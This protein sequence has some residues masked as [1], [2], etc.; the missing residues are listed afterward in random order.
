MIK[1]ASDFL[2][3]QSYNDFLDDM[4]LIAEHVQKDLHK[5]AVSKGNLAFDYVYLNS[6][7]IPKEYRT[8]AYTKHTCFRL[9]YNIS[10]VFAE[11]K[12]LNKFEEHLNLIDS[13]IKD[14]FNVIHS[15]HNT[16]GISYVVKIN[17]R[18][19]NMIDSAKGIKKYS[20]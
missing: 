17:D 2:N 10:N 12:N 8:N 13:E 6:V 20:L 1:R 5:I 14:I 18:L 15:E 9:R 16:E 19:K 4:Y 7:F 11:F 3:E